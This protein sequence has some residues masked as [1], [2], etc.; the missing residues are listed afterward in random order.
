MYGCKDGGRPLEMR[1]KHILSMFLQI[2]SSVFHGQCKYVMLA[3]IRVIIAKTLDKAWH[4]P[5]TKL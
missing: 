1:I 2:W 4:Y 5:F 3:T